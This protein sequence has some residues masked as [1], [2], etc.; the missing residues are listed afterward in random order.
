VAAVG[1]LQ[2]VVTQGVGEGREFDI[3]ASAQVLGRDAA[4]DIVLDDPEASRRH[5]S[6]RAEG[7]SA[8]VEDLG[9]T[10]GTFVNEER[11]AGGRTLSAGDRVRIGTTVLEL[12][13]VAQ[14]TRVGTAIP[15][16]LGGQETRLGGAV[17]GGVAP[18]AGP[19]APGGVPEAGPPTEVPAAPEPVAAAAAAEPGADAPEPAAPA[20]E[21]PADEPAGPPT[22]VSAA[23]E[24]VAESPAAPS[25]APGGPPL[26]GAPGGEPPTGTPGAPPPSGA[27]G[28][29]PPSGTPGG[30][31]SSTPPPPGP[32]PAPGGGPPPPSSPPGPPPGGPPPPSSPPPPGPPP[33]GPPPP[34]SPPPPGPPPGGGPPPPSFPPPG[35]PPPGPAPSGY[36]PPTAG[37]G[38]AAP[39]AVPAPYA[40]GPPAFGAYPIEFEADHPA[41]GIARWRPFLQGFLAIPHMIALFFVFVAMFFVYL[42]AWVAIL[43]TGEY[44]RGMFN[45]VSGTLRWQARVNGYAVLMTEAYPPFS[46]DDD[47]GYPIRARFQYP[48]KIAR[49]RVFLQG[50]MAIPHFIALAFVGFGAAIAAWIALIAIIFTRNYPPGL[51]NFVAGY[52]RWS[53]RATGYA[54]LLTEEYPPFGLA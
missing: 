21:P 22:E 1:D 5:A 9:S 23:P 39:G 42:V 30:T 6:I 17:P 38:Y 14:A 34:S 36:P 15:E 27:P 50:L 44:P 12:R 24:P 54:Y 25:G 41:A 10:N 51:F 2:L 47:P 40:G 46:L 28:G 7:G 18:G 19:E 8:V 52:Y 49:W 13:S 53:L 20:P 32:P 4:S 45:F 11:I 48:A 43:F 37:P 35:G 26:S 16:D 3:A 31:P 33:G 29:E